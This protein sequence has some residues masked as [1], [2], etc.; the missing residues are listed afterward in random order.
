[1]LEVAQELSAGDHS[2]Q[3][4]AEGMASGIFMYRLQAG[5]FFETK[6]S[7]HSNNPLAKPS[8]VCV[9][10]AVTERFDDGYRHLLSRQQ[11]T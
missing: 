2:Y 3:W 6:N 8:T 4:T 1:M 7:F 10:A 9:F 5:S 11:N